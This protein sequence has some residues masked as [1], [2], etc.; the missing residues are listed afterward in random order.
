MALASVH[1]TSDRHW[2]LSESFTL[3]YTMS[4][5]GLGLLIISN[6]SSVTFMLYIG[7]HN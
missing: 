6:E 1:V 5:Y 2:T 7:I 3:W 4:P